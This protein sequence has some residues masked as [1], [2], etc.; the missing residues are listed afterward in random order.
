MQN[1]IDVKI[2]SL[3]DSATSKADQEKKKRLLEWL[4]PEEV[5]PD[6][7]YEA[8][9]LSRQPSTGQWFLKSD[10]FNAWLEAKKS[11]FLWL[12]SIRKYLR[13]ME[14]NYWAEICHLSWLR[15]DCSLVSSAISVNRDCAG[16]LQYRIS[17]RRCNSTTIIEHVRSY[18][19]TQDTGLVYFY[20]DH[21]DSR[22]QNVSNFAATAIA[23]LVKQSSS[24]YTQIEKWFESSGHEL[25]QRLPSS[26]YSSLLKAVAGDFTR[27]VI[28][29]DALDECDDLPALVQSFQ[30]LLSPST[31]SSMHILATSRN[32]LVI[33]RLILPLTTAE[34]SLMRNIREDIVT[35]V[36]TEVD[37]RIRSKRLKL[38]NPDLGKQIKIA[39]LKNSDGM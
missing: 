38:R 33:E 2:D 5:D 8:A 28:V 14:M 25:N 7:N 31:L 32:D 37:D 22:K 10:I 27:T 1:R 26:E 16:T 24:C 39:L 18:V 35:Y 19:I 6:Q 17:S 9:L 11:S 15:Q 30:V 13:T 12:H 21:R 3:M 34:L 20:F 29:L 36:T 4:R 23:Q